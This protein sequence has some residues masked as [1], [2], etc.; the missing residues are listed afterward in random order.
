M[1]LEERRVYARRRAGDRLSIPQG[2]DWKCAPPSGEPGPRSSFNTSRV[3]LEA[4]DEL[5]GSDPLVNFQYLKGAIGRGAGRVGS[6]LVG[7]FNTSRVRLEDRPA[8]GSGGHGHLSIPQ[9][10]D[11]KS[12]RVWMVI[13]SE[14]LSIPQGCDWKAWTSAGAP[15]SPAPLSIPQGCDWKFHFPLRTRPGRFLSIPQGCDWKTFSQIVGSIKVPFQYLK[16]AIGRKAQARTRKTASP[17][18]TSRVRLEAASGGSYSVAARSFQY[19]KGAI[20]RRS[21]PRHATVIGSPFNTS[22]VRLEAPRNTTADPPPCP[23]FQYLKG[24]IGSGT[25]T[26]YHEGAGFFQYLKGAIG[27]VPD[28]TITTPRAA[29]NTSRVRLEVYPNLPKI[30]RERKSSRGDR[31]FS[32]GRC[33]RPSVVQ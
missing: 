17:F 3:R 14:R 20:G 8:R 9:G 26:D 31:L 13:R 24:A 30:G 11:W 29:F 10:C 4:D 5:E 18:N 7:P 33:R 15:N 25:P 6:A 21:L 22:R 16:G 28:F 27:S 32:P 12:W 2:C 19:L 1:R 23:P